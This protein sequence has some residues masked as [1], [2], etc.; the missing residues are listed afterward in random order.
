[1]ATHRVLS[2][3]NQA[4][5]DSAEPVKSR[6][7][8]SA[9]QTT[10][11]PRRA[12]GLRLRSALRDT[13]G[14]GVS[15]V[16]IADKRVAR[17]GEEITFLT[18]VINDTRERLEHIFLIPRSFTNAG[19]VKLSYLSQPH[20]RHLTFGPMLPATAAA[21]TFTYI[22]SADDQLQRG[23]VLSAMMVRARS[24]NGSLLWDECDALVEL[25]L[26]TEPSIQDTHDRAVLNHRSRPEL[27]MPGIASGPVSGYLLPRDSALGV[28]RP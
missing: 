7:P 25:E 24:A 6:F 15:L 13:T 5:G 23:G 21:F 4:A 1:M 2:T 26:P 14:N 10:F 9:V 3:I 11:S 19:M 27:A 22:A 28:G 17:P 18:W 8:S 12:I 16:H 20:P